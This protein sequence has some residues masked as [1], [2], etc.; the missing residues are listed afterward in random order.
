MQVPAM[1]PAQSVGDEGAQTR[2]SNGAEHA[3][4]QAATPFGSL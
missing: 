2:F 4:A 1:L 3:V